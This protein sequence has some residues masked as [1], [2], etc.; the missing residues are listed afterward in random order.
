MLSRAC[1]DACFTCSGR[2]RRPASFNITV[3]HCARQAAGRMADCGGRPSS[4]RDGNHRVTS[5]RTPATYGITPCDG[6]SCRPVRT[7]VRAA[8]PRMGKPAALDPR[9]PIMLSV[10]PLLSALSREDEAHRAR[11]TMTRRTRNIQGGTPAGVRDAAPAQEQV[12]RNQALGPIASLPAAI[13]SASPGGAVAPRTS[14]PPEAFRTEPS[15]V[16]IWAPESAATTPR[17]KRRPG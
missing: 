13:C 7:V 6:R 9:R 14:V 11:V 15:A 5:A 4:R 1:T 12:S 17:G 16:P 10:S 2:N 8:V 3:A